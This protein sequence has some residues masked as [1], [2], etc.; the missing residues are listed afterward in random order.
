MK[1]TKYRLHKIFAKNNETRKKIKT[2]NQNHTQ[3]Q[4]KRTYCSS[5]SNTNRN[6]KPYDKP[7]NLKTRTLKRI[8]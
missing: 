1:L 7:F 4:E 8:I 5:H 6:I 3:N 2:N